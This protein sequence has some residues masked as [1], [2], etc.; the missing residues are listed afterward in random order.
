MNKRKKA[1]HPSAV[2]NLT[3]RNLG[4]GGDGMGTH[5]GKPVYVPKTTPGDVVRV[6]ARETAE[7]YYGEVLGIERPSPARVQAPCPHYATCGGCALQHIDAADYRAWKADKVKATLDRAGVFPETM[8]NP[9]FLPAATRRRTT[10]AVMRT[11]EGLVMGYHAPRSHRI[12]PIHHCM[13][14]DPALDALVHR[15]PAYLARLAPARTALDITLQS[16]GNA[17]DV[18]LTGSWQ[19]DGTFTLEQN[20]V[21]SAML[22][23]LDLARISLRKKETDVP[24]VILSRKPVVK[25]F[26]SLNVALPPAA[27]L[28][29]S[30]KGEQVLCDFVT[31]HLQGSRQVA[32]LFCGCGTFAGPL[33]E[34]GAEVY[35]ADSEAQAISALCH[36]R[37]K[38][39]RRNLFKEPLGLSELSRF[40]AAVIDPPRAGA[41]EQ[42]RIL[43]ESAVPKIV[44][45]SCNPA[46]FARDA[47]LLIAGGY[48]LKR[49][50]I[51]DQFVWSPHVELAALFVR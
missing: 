4:A 9:A 11:A 50:K 24:E 39:Q 47:S 30:T 45:V 51:V 31:T 37:L 18:V 15:L 28:Q 7:A 10:L 41:K 2:F 3:I 42:F 35:A 36:P 5:D 23:E 29:A 14:L 32:D 20:E 13:I 43:A 26:G 33:L 34:A 1:K 49:L 27:F 25:A 17:L 22:N 8:E 16:A 19:A 21:L 40:D 12:T 6:R 38:A 44:S 46:T 48:A